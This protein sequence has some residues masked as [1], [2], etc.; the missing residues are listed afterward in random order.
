MAAA[1]VIFAVLQERGPRMS[2]YFCSLVLVEI[3]YELFF[4]MLV[5]YLES[6]YNKRYDA[7]SGKL[8]NSCT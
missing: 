2:D 7:R 1:S 5:G 4:A 8:L 3:N 6:Y